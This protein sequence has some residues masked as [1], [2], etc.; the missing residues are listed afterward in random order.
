VRDEYHCLAAR[1]RSVR[2]FTGLDDEGPDEVSDGVRRRLGRP[3]ASL[4]SVSGTPRLSHV[5]P[6]SM[7][8]AES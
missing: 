2:L 3:L 8:F 5:E 6:P 7:T 4:R 1:L